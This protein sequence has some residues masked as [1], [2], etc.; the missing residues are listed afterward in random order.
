MRRARTA[1]RSPSGGFTILELL[2]ATT[3]LVVGVLA[4][5]TTSAGVA[6]MSGAG[7]LQ[8]IAVAAAESRLETMRAAPCGTLAPGSSSARGVREQWSVVGAV[9][10]TDS[11]SFETTAGTRTFGLRTLVKC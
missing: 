2:V 10:V 3:I 8:L 4:L 7:A 9:D 6:R 11:V 1:L 5:V